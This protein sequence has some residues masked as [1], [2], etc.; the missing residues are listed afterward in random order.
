M[1][2]V[3]AAHL[4]CAALTSFIS[5]IQMKINGVTWLAEAS[6]CVSSCRL[7]ETARCQPLF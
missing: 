1:R 3:S 6:V 5:F 4:R 2:D 7:N